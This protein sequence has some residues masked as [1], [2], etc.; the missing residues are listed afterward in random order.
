MRTSSTFALHKREMS[1]T[2][3]SF[4]TKM[5]E[6][7]GSPKD[8]PNGDLPTRRCILRKMLLE[9]M[10]ESREVDRYIKH[11]TNIEMA[12]KVAKSTLTFWKKVNAKIVGALVTEQE[13]LVVR[14]SHT[15]HVCFM[16]SKS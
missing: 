12:E 14:A 6:L 15:R 13:I 2:R 11:V 9:K 4:T 1:G 3:S 5:T 7:V 10:V 16:Q 8:L